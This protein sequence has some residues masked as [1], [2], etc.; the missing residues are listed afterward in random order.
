MEYKDIDTKLNTDANMHIDIDTNLYSR[1]IYTVGLDAMLNISKA[2]VFLYNL[3]SLGIEIAKCLVLL[4]VNTLNIND[5]TQ[6]TDT[7]I[8]QNFCFANYK[9]KINTDKIDTAKIYLQGL[10]PSVTITTSKYSISGNEHLLGYDV[11]II[12]DITLILAVYVNTICRKH[13]IKFIYAQT[14][15]VMGFVFTD[16]GDYYKVDDINGEKIKTGSLIKIK[17]NILTTDSN[18]GLSKGDTVKLNIFNKIIT[19]TITKYTVNSFEVDAILNTLL[20]TTLDKTDG[21]LINSFYTEV[22]QPKIFNF[23]SLN[24]S[25][26]NPEFTIADYCDFT[27]PTTLHNFVKYLGQYENMCF[28]DISRPY[29]EDDANFI[30]TL[31]TERSNDS[32]IDLNIIRKL[33]YTCTQILY[34]VV[35]II[36]SFAA[37]EVIKAITNKFTPIKQWLYYD[38]LTLLDNDPINN[39]FSDIFKQKIAD[40]K[41]FIVGA[42]AIGCEHLKNFVMLGVGNIVITDMDTIEKS[43]LNRQFLFRSKDINKHKSETA[44][45]SIKHI[46]PKLNIIAHINKVCKETEFIYNETFIKS[47]TC[48]TNALDNIEARLYVDNLCLNNKIPLLEAGTLGTSGNVQTIIPYLTETYADTQ[49]PVDDSV[50]VCTIKNFPYSSEHTIVWGRDLF[51]ELFNKIPTNFNKFVNMTV[52]NLKELDTTNLTMLYTDV[53]FIINNYAVCFDDCIKIAHKIYNS[54]FVDNIKDLLIKYPQNLLLDEIL[55]WSGTK[56]CP[57]IMNYNCENILHKKFINIFAKLWWYIFNVNTNKILNIVL[58]KILNIV[59]ECYDTYNTHEHDIMLNNLIKLKNIYVNQLNT[60]IFDKNNDLDIEFIHNA[61]NIRCDN[62]DIKKTDILETKK[63]AGNI[64]PALITT[65]SLVSG[66]VCIE[67][68]KL[69]KKYNTLDKYRNS[70]INLATSMMGF[71]EPAP[72]KKRKIGDLLLSNWDICEFTNIKLKEIIIWFENN[73]LET[74]MI[75]YDNKLIYSYLSKKYNND[76]ILNTEILNL[77][78]VINTIY[79]DVSIIDGDDIHVVKIKIN[80]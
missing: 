5:T 54:N 1:Q 68:C 14:Y 26:D 71:S 11:V 28:D 48:I 2:K 61:S 59:L 4:G 67:Y 39:I 63:I 70:Y 65:T 42:G 10:N 80:K 45:N 76:E 36:G 29:N 22:K 9:N 33:T 13:N 50:P 60:I 57:K 77:C 21:I 52:D 40:S 53:V 18:H 37:Q 38:A 6:I 43:N 31:C 72:A 32:N 41:V 73:N 7:D 17:N 12:S 62:Y 64:I 66:L 34:P 3:N 35:S 49:D 55:F 46:N 74:A 78:N 30:C 24:E 27:R 69:I 20:N 58:D 15:G 47:L 44:V 19:T 56:K 79:L 16:F 51:E 23:L 25:L 75:Y 8:E